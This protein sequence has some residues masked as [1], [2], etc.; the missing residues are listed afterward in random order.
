MERA[1]RQCAA[2]RCGVRK[3]TAA[4]RGCATSKPIPKRN[5]RDDSP[6]TTNSVSSIRGP[7]RRWKGSPPGRITVRAPTERRSRKCGVPNYLASVRRPIV[8]TL[9]NSSADSSFQ[10][11]RAA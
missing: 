8:L 1:A 9:R 5:F 3:L 2:A 4:V 11:K 6:G 7:L 10:A